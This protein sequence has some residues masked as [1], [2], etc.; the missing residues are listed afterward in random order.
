MLCQS[1]HSY[2]PYSGALDKPS[3]TRTG[4]D[5]AVPRPWHNCLRVIVHFIRSGPQ[6]RTICLANSS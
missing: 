5:Y 2:A 3:P 1:S 4:A 6:K